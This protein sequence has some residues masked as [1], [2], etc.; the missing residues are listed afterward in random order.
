MFTKHFDYICTRDAMDDVQDWKR[1]FT[2]AFNQLKNCGCHEVQ[3]INVRGDGPWIKLFNNS[4]KEI[5]NARDPSLS[6]GLDMNDYK[7]MMENV[8]FS[9]VKIESSEVCMLSKFDQVKLTLTQELI[10]PEDTS[11]EAKDARINVF[12]RVRML[13]GPIYAFRA[14]SGQE[15]PISE[16]DFET[17][18]QKELDERGFRIYYQIIHGTKLGEANDTCKKRGIIISKNH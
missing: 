14:T 16:S 7:Q 10:I 6:Y 8:G 13:I 9:N 11:P 18:V 15:I 3:Q 2:Q 12:S 4:C 17:N 5:M 1:F